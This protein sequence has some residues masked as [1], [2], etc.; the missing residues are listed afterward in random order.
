MI[1]EWIV[2]ARNAR[3]ERHRGKRHHRGRGY[4]I[5]AITN[6]TPPRAYHL[7]GDGL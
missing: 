7:P 2:V 1:S 3:A 4:N 5:D 6:K